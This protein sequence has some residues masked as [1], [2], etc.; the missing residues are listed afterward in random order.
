MASKSVFR[1][2]KW[3]RPGN[4]AW[5]SQL[6]KLGR[7]G[8]PP[9]TTI[10]LTIP[11]TN[12]DQIDMD[13]CA[14]KSDLAKSARR[15]LATGLAMLGTIG[16]TEN[17]SI[18]Q[19]PITAIEP[20][21][22]VSAGQNDFFAGPTNQ[23]FAFAS[24]IGDAFQR[25]G[26]VSQASFQTARPSGS[27]Q[28]NARPASAGPWWSSSVMAPIRHAN[29]AVPIELDTLFA[30][31]ASHSH[32]VQAIAQTP[33]VNEMQEQQARAAFDPTLYSD[34][35]FDSISD[36]VENTLTTGGP[37]RLEDDIVSLDS[38]FRGRASVAA[39]IAS[40]Q[41]LGHKN[42]N[43]N[44]F[45]PNNQGSARLYANMTHPLMQGRAIDANRSL[46][47]T[48]HFE[49]EAARAEYQEALQKQ[50]FD[51]ADAYWSLYTERASLLQRQR[52]LARATEIAQML[53]FRAGHDAAQTQV[54]RARATVANR[55]AELA[56]ADAQIRN[57][58]SRLRALVNAPY[59]SQDR[60]AEFSANAARDVASN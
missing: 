14:Q 56:Q 47:L 48:A 12:D 2:R 15:L 29:Q 35:R 8:D 21:I 20:A 22:F 27:P 5:L 18:A 1:L 24:R 57:V 7:S 52:N 34:N 51:V 45:F 30:L 39:P 17:S 36:P 13:D 46:I 55:T 32:R 44:F 11:A 42:S 4:F 54:L 60:T 6:G 16:F 28:A 59:L 49:T 31:T 19:T 43:S 40:G 9:I 50:L 53:S 3:Q 10:L 58:E 23:P 33:W 26:N 37:P 41:R 38:G 25:G